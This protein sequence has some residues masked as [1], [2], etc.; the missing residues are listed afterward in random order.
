M[1]CSV[2]FTKTS[3]AVSIV[4]AM[5]CNV[6]GANPE[7]AG[8]APK[9]IQA[10]C[11]VS[12]RAY[13]FDPPGHPPRHRRCSAHRHDVPLVIWHAKTQARTCGGECKRRITR[14][15]KMLSENYAGQA[16][17]LSC[18]M[19]GCVGVGPGRRRDIALLSRRCLGGRMSAPMSAAI[20]A[21]DARIASLTLWPRTAWPR[22]APRAMRS[23]P[24]RV[25]PPGPRDTEARSGA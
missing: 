6:P 15:T 5:S 2:E 1:D 24:M 8:D 23:T 3:R 7:A 16:R 4:I 9:P 14:G 18:G 12:T 25:A 19:S 21:A 17:L 13:R 22:R 20:L 10:I 11:S